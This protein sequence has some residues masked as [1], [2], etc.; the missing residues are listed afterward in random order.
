MLRG[1]G[2]EVV[3]APGARAGDGPRLRAGRAG[4]AGRPRRARGGGGETVGRFVREGLADK[5]TVFY[6]PKVLGSGGTPLMGSLAVDAVG[7]APG[8]R[9]DE[10]ERFGEDVALTLYPARTE[11]S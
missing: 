9:V 7:R 11:E 8:F 1:R 3:T 10:V 2:V 6:A 5:L 4:A